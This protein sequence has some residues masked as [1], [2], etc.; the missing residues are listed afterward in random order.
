MCL[1][2]VKW[3]LLRLSVLFVCS[4]YALSSSSLS[5]GREVSM[6]IYTVKQG[7]NILQIAQKLG[8]SAPQILN[9]NPGIRS[10][11]PGVGLR[12]PRV[13]PTG[14]QKLGMPA[15]YLE[16]ER[17]QKQAGGQGP[18]PPGGKRGG[19]GGGQ[20]PIPPR[21]TPPKGT[22]YRPEE[23]RKAPPPPSPRPPQFKPYAP[24]LVI[25]R[26]P[27]PLFRQREQ[28]LT[29]PGPFVPPQPQRG[30][31]AQYY[32]PQWGAGYGATSALRAFPGARA[33][34]TVTRRKPKY[35]IG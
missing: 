7:E 30:A 33:T 20:L 32:A 28:A 6:P 8:L 12:V 9:L 13:P 1:R 19:G 34:A 25:P 18:P 22:P 26:P 23:G 3:I 5:L 21:F 31:A 17:G 11:S 29:A 10:L 4:V 24:K 16:S 35:L 14:A 2:S 27:V 15:A